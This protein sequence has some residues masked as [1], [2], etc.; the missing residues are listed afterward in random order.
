MTLNLTNKTFGRLTAIER[1]PNNGRRTAWK[2][3]CSCGVEK[4]INSE[5]VTD[6]RVNSCGCLQ[7][8]S[9]TQRSLKH[10]HS[11]NR[12]ST[13]ELK[14]YA[15]AKSRCY[16]KNDPKYKNYGLRGIKMCDAWL[17]D[18]SQFLKD[19]GKA[20]SPKHSI[21]RIDVNGDYEPSNCIWATNHDQSRNKTT[22]VFVEL[23]GEMVILK[24]YALALGIGYK[25]LHKLYRKDGMTLKDA[26]DKLLKK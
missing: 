12:K 25:A 20:P 15:H 13:K 17:N 6:G 11:I 14:S 3:L 5:T 1:M 21:E 16:N 7:K 18:A 23:N 2:F 26:T 9:I 24:D 10:G 19:M 8:E 4:I 22:N